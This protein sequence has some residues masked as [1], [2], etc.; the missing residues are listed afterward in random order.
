MRARLSPESGLSI[1][2][3]CVY[4]FVFEL[5]PSKDYVCTFESAL[6]K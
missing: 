2:V 5:I 3:V 1:K 4:L 6:L